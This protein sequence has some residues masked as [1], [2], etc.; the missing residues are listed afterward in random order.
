MSK[1]FSLIQTQVDNLFKFNVQSDQGLVLPTWIPHQ[2]YLRP[3]INIISAI[4]FILVVLMFG[5]F[6]WNQGLAPV[7]SVIAP[8]GEFD[9]RVQYPAF[10]QLIVTLLAL[11]MI[12]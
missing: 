10:T 4:F 7:F 12:L 5:K 11:M 1:L 9:R 8:I 6:L 3:V 2:M